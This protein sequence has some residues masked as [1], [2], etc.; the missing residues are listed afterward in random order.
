MIDMLATLAVAIGNFLVGVLFGIRITR[1]SGIWISI[2]VGVVLGALGWFF[3]KIGLYTGI[4]ILLLIGIFEL[5][6]YSIKRTYAH[7][8]LIFEGGG[9]RRGLTPV[10]A[11]ILLEMDSEVLAIIGIISLMDK[12][13]I[14]FAA[15]Y[16]GNGLEVVPELRIGAKTINPQ[17]RKKMR[18]AVGRSLNQTI[19]PSEDVLIEMI[20]QNGERVFGNF[21]FA[22]WIEISRKECDKKMAGFDRDQTIDYYFEYINH[23]LTG[24]I[25]GYFPRQDYIAWMVLE[26]YLRSQGENFID[27]ILNNTQPGWLTDKETLLDWITMLDYAILSSDN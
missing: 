3:P 5:W 20:E 25:K 16:H 27:P 10:E 9:I 26:Y 18:K 14:N 19:S 23:R 8:H 21:Q 7:S 13:L 1:G 15:D 4:F 22:V 2:G 11:A 17:E 24:V 6:Q 12:G